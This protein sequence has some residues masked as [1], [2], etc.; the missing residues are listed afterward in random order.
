MRAIKVGVQLQ[1]QGTSIGD[2][3]AAWQAA[4]AMG[5]DS[6]W[7][8][9]HFFALFGPSE[10]SH[11]EGWTLLSAMAVDT[12]NAQIGLLVGCNSYRN[13]D[14]L[15]DMARTVDHLSGGRVYLGLGSGWFERDYAEYG[16][17]FGTAARRLHD[18]GEALPRIRARL[19]VLNPGP[20]GRLPILIGGGGEKVTL[21]LTAQHADAWN[22]FGPPANFGAKNA[23][24][25]TWCDKLGRDRG[26]IER[27]VAIGADDVGNAAAYVDAGATHIIVM[28]G[29]P[30]DLRPVEKL[31]ATLGE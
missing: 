18:L 17:E 19:G 21:K 31:L 8:W 15:A 29:Y 24:L 10:A 20:V 25:D 22:T 23:I 26:A 4:D 6:I 14:L 7:T 3:R 2:L 12:K 30:F 9:D 1:P 11:F 27:T 13:P 5:L 16:Y 28:I